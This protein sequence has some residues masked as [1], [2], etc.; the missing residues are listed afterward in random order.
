MLS[1]V[2]ISLIAAVTCRPQLPADVSEAQCPN[3]PLCSATVVDLSAFTPAQQVKTT[4]QSQDIDT[5]RKLS[6]KS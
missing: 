1:V 4:E 2:F 3:F 5:S 6:G